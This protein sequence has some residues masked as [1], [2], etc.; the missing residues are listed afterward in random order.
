MLQSGLLEDTPSGYQLN[1]PLPALA[2]LATLQDSLMARLD[3]LAPAKEVAQAGAVIGR[4]FGHRLM[5]EVLSDMTPAKLDAA[6]ADLVRSELVFRRGTPPD[7][8]YSF[9]HALVRDTAYNSMLELGLRLRLGNALFQSEGFTST[10]A[11]ENCARVGDLALSLDQPD[12]HLQACGGLAARLSAAGR[13]SEANALLEQFGPAEL[14]RLKPMS[15]VNRLLRMGLSEDAARRVG[16]GGEP[17]DRGPPRT[18]K[19]ETRRPA[20]A[21]AGAIRWSRC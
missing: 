3:R 12:D 5:A 1:G 16:A 11:N 13:F 8:T 4:E 15:R 20:A 21:R 17:P 14:A 7:A 18:R 6:L 19:R 9:K 10:R 2:I